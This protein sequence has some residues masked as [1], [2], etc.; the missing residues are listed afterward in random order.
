MNVYLAGKISKNVWRHQIV[1]GLRCVDFEGI[2]RITDYPIWGDGISPGVNYSGPYFVGCDHGCYHG[3]NSHGV[4]N[5]IGECSGQA[6]P[7]RDH[8][9][10]LGSARI[11][12]DRSNL[13]FAWIEDLTCFGTLAEIGYAR[14]RNKFIAIGGLYFSDLW[15]VY[16]MADCLPEEKDP[17]EA[18]K[19]AIRFYR[20]TSGAKLITWHRSIQVFMEHQQSTGRHHPP[21]QF[22]PPRMQQIGNH[23]Y[24]SNT[25]GASPFLAYAN[26]SATFS[27]Q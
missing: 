20:K 17:N 22:N 3:R 15:F 24:A 14:G 1:I 4:F 18:L 19:E 13:V 12:I 11:Q 21:G 8:R 26:S 5:L 25:R 9:G 10:V 23:A 27:V 2:E 7:A 16:E 6:A